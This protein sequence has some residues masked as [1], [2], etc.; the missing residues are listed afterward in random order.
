MTFS[1]KLS[2]SWLQSDKFS[3]LCFKLK[4]LKTLKYRVEVAGNQLVVI[5]KNV[6]NDHT[7]TI[8]FMIPG[9]SL[10]AVSNKRICYFYSNIL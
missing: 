5:V 6:N 8:I 3:K 9:A 4:L 10:L 2:S 1:F 7:P